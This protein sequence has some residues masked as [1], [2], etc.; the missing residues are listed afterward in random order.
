MS[1][2][3][4]AMMICPKGVHKAPVSPTISICIIYSY[5]IYSFDKVIF[6]EIDHIYTTVIGRHVEFMHVTQSSGTNKCRN[7]FLLSNLVL[8]YIIF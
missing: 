4:D 8:H 5:K 1:N 3:N 7:R 2:I 6:I